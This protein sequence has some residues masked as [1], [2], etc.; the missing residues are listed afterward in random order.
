MATDVHIGG[1]T[2]KKRNI[3]AVWLLLP[4]IT[5]G[6]YHVVW[7]YKINNEARRYLGDPSIKPV[8][9]VLA[10]VPGFVIIVPPLVSVY[11]TGERVRRMQQRAGLVNQTTPWIALALSF[12][13]SLHSLY[14]QMGLNDVW[15]RYLMPWSPTPAPPPYPS[16][17]PQGGAPPPPAAQPPAQ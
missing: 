7:W 1:E 14:I 15:D 10:L 12:V 4:L 8:L 6:V 2:Y 3:F 5:L 9:S 17:T 11:R 16:A 13:F